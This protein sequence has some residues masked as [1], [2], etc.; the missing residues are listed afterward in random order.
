M[1]IRFGICNVRNLCRSVSLKTAAS[2]LAMYN[3]DLLAVPNIR[4]VEGGSQPADDYTI[5]YGNGNVYHNL[6]TGLIY[7]RESYQL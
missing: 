5:F 4:W 1:D 2:E 3:L 6:W 7:V